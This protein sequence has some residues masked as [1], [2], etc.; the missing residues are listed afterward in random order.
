M[1]L[2]RLVCATPETVRENAPTVLGVDES[3]LRKGHVYGTVLIDIATRCPEPAV[4]AEHVRTFA[5]MMNNLD[6]HLLDYWI[7]AA[8]DSGPA[9]LAAFARGLTD[10]RLRG[11]MQRTDPALQ[12]RSR[13]RQRQPHHRRFGI[14]AGSTSDATAAAREPSCCQ[15]FAGEFGQQLSLARTLRGGDQPL[16]LIL[17][18]VAAFGSGGACMPCGVDDRR[19]QDVGWQALAPQETGFV[20]VQEVEEHVHGCRAIEAEP[21][22]PRE[23]HIALDVAG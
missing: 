19:V 13:R 8:Q 9:P 22:Q 2:L 23:P 11:R 21:G 1:T 6:G 15:I 18:K 4:L 17:G 16:S 14:G 10:H 5:T 20:G 7:V 3:G 12:L